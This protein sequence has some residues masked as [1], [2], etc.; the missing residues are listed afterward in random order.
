MAR[1]RGEGR[2]PTGPLGPFRPTVQPNTPAPPPATPCKRCGGEGEVRIV[3]AS[4]GKMVT[5][6]RCH[7]TGREPG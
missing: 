4:G 7:G 1:R 2:G 5:C 3:S 6:P